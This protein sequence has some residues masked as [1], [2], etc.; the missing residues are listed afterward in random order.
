MG[1]KLILHYDKV[2]GI[3]DVERARRSQGRNPASWAARL[4]RAS[5]PHNGDVESLEIPFTKRLEKGVF[6]WPM[7][8]AMGD[9]VALSSGQ[10]ALLLEGIDWRAPE[11]RWRPEKVA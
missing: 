2:G 4:S 6:A 10:L 1:E 11:R 9:A 8:G 5:Y 7:L 3:L